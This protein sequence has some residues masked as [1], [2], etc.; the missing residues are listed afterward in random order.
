MAVCNKAQFENHIN[1][2]MTRVST[3]LALEQRAKSQQAK[4]NKKFTVM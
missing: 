1:E 2:G 3:K 4:L